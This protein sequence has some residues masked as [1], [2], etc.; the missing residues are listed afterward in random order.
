MAKIIEVK[1][2]PE[3]Y[4]AVRTGVKPWELRYNDRDYAEGDLLILRE[5][6][7]EAYTG[8]RQTVKIT[9]ILREFAGL[10][11]GWVIMSVQRF[12]GGKRK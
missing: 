2:L 10:A 3:Y 9:Y 6:N 5:W 7:G 4:E 11:E 1:C 12:T 8:R